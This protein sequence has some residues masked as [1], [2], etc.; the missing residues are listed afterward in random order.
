MNRA[1][2]NDLS[3]LL[4]LSDCARLRRDSACLGARPWTLTPAT[5]HVPTVICHPVSAGAVSLDLHALLPEVCSL[6]EGG[7]CLTVCYCHRR[8]AAGAGPG[9]SRSQRV[10]A[11]L[12]LPDPDQ[13]FT[14]G[15]LTC[16]GQA[17]LYPHIDTIM[18]SLPNVLM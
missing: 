17:R 13:R 14:A 16:H 6:G 3:L 18:K 4:S 7:G 15:L 5:T 1:F 9:T 2:T 8:A 11:G 10:P 12:T